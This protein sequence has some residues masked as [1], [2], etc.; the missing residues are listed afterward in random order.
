MSEEPGAKPFCRVYD[1]SVRLVVSAFLLTVAMV[2]ADTLPPL[3][4][5]PPPQSVEGS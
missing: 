3:E 4:G 1:Y 5:C 2:G